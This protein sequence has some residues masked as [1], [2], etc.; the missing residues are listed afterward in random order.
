MTGLSGVT[1]H[2]TSLICCSDRLCWSSRLS[3]SYDADKLAVERT[4]DDELN[5]TFSRCKQGVILAYANVFT[6]MKAGA[7]LTDNDVA[8]DDGLTAVDFHAKSFGL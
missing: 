3:G 1:H 6:C 7:T 8:R 2:A 5:A 4:F